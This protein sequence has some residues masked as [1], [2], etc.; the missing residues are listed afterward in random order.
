MERVSVQES[1]C[2]TRSLLVR[3]CF[4]NM[5]EMQITDRYN[6]IKHCHHCA[7]MVIAVGATLTGS[8]RATRSYSDRG[9]DHG[10]RSVTYCSSLVAFERLHCRY[11]SVPVC[12]CVLLRS[13]RC[14]A[15]GS[16]RVFG[17]CRMLR[18][19]LHAHLIYTVCVTRKDTRIDSR[20]DD[21]HRGRDQSLSQRPSLSCT[22]KLSCS[23][24]ASCPGV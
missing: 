5:L 8:S 12:Q 10:Y 15:S 17:R 7:R 22:A 3:V 11:A 9:L 6:A 1:L 19:H 4:A 18:R 24:R 16:H 23:N 20:G 13:C 14:L 2:L 21:Q